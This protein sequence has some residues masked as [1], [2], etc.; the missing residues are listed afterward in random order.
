MYVGEG[1]MV[2]APTEGQLVDV[3]PIRGDGHYIGA[4]RIVG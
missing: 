2:D 3:R 1:K 4:R